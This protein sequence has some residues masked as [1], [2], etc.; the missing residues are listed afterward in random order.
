MRPTHALRL[1]FACEAEIF[2]RAQAARHRKLVVEKYKYRITAVTYCTSVYTVLGSYD[3]GY[4]I[5]DLADMFPNGEI[6]SAVLV[7]CDKFGFMEGLRLAFVSIASSCF[8]HASFRFWTLAFLFST[9]ASVRAFTIY[10]GPPRPTA[11]FRFF[12]FS[13]LPY[14]PRSLSICP[15]YPSICSLLVL[16]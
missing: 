14:C 8:A 10:A 5:S 9:Q 2:V 16:A 7:D 6:K 11:V 12:P 15:S 1:L 13:P 4:E 3:I